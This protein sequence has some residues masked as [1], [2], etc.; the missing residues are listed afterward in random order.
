MAETLMDSKAVTQTSE[1]IVDLFR[2]VAA[3]HSSAVAIERAEKRVRYADLENRSEE[4]T[5]R[6]RSANIS[7]GSVVAIVSD[8]P[9]D[10]IT[11]MLGVLRQA[12]FSFPLIH[13]FRNRD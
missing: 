1:R 3:Q 2:R 6:L 13:R 12:P 4:V 9:V 8:D 10:V 11:A 5:S 7:P